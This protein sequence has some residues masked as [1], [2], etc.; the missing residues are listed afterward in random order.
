MKN[1][2]GRQTFRQSNINC[3]R[4]FSSWNMELKSKIQH[5]SVILCLTNPV[6]EKETA[7]MYYMGGYTPK[8]AA[9]NILNVPS[10]VIIPYYVGSTI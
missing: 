5:I 7:K 4:S 6:L 3:I 9:E 10:K 2:K 8:I 1:Q